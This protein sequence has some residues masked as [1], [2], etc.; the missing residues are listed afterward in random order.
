MIHAKCSSE[1]MGLTPVLLAMGMA[2]AAPAWSASERSPIDLKGYGEL[3]D[4]VVC[5]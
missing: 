4:S 1:L 2:F 3:L 5:R